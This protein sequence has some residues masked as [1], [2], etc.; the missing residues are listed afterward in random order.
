MCII[1][2]EGGLPGSGTHTTAI[3][4][5]Y[6]TT[7]YIHSVSPTSGLESIAAKRPAKLKGNTLIKFDA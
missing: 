3:N 2:V 7:E 1:N 4:S 5:E 6:Y